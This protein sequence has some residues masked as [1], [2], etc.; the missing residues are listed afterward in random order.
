MPL[1]CGLRLSVE[2]SVVGVLVLEVATLLVGVVPGVRGAEGI[3]P[4]AEQRCGAGVGQAVTG[5][6]ESWALVRSTVPGQGRADRLTRGGA[7]PGSSG[8]DDA[9]W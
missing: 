5:R 2:G 4:I 1:S 3:I 8:R 7:G 9:W 6:A